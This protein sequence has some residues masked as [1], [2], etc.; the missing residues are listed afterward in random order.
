[1]D[2]LVMKTESNGDT[3]WTNT[4]DFGPLDYGMSIKPISYHSYIITGY[5]QAMIAPFYNAFLLHLDSSGGVNWTRFYGGSGDDD[6]YSVQVMDDGG[7]VFTGYTESFGAGNDDV[8]LVRTDST[9]DTLWTKTYGG[10]NNDIGQEVQ[11]TSDGGFIICGHTN[12]FGNGFIDVYVVKTEG[13]PAGVYGLGKEVAV[14]RVTATPNPARDGVTIQYSLSRPGQVRLSVHD[15]RGRQ[16][17]IITDRRC[18]AGM[19]TTN[20]D[21]RDRSGRPA[22]PGIYFVSIETDDFRATRKLV[23]LH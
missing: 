8:W 3:I 7:F 2:V 23:L 4:Y 13:D 14:P 21:G 5:S 12:S 20:W 10:S 1:M 9:G 18:D 16:V 19:H 17:G 22:G 15:V 6:G 11:V